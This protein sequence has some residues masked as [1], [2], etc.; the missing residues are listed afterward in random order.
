MIKKGFQY[1][2]ILDENGEP[3]EATLD[4]WSAWFETDK[5]QIARYERDGSFVSTIFLGL[6]HNF[7]DGPPLLWETMMFHQGEWG[8]ERRAASKE[9]ALQNHAN[10]CKLLD[11]KLDKAFDKAV[12][13][14]EGKS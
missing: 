12:K 5:R 6:D 13:F 8:P 1:H 10:M 14:I 7:G 4:E 9:D 11:K 3:K 2:W